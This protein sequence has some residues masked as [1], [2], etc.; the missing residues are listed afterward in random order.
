M[1]SRQVENSENTMR[2][3]GSAGATMR[4]WPDGKTV[5]DFNK[6][7]VMTATRNGDKYTQIQRGTKNSHTETRSGQVF[8]S[9][10]SG[11]STIE[12][13]RNGKRLYKQK[14]IPVSYG[15]PYI[16]TETRITV[17]GGR[18][19]STDIFQRLSHTP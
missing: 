18:D 19:A 6:S 1:T 10:F 17:Y 15:L 4:V 8:S 11:N 13:I 7:A 3:S 2:F 16:C 14:S 5:L 9:E 12:M